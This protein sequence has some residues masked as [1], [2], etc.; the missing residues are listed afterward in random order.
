MAELILSGWNLNQG[1]IAINNWYSGGSSVLSSTTNNTLLNTNSTT[2]VAPGVTWGIGFGKGLNLISGA[3]ATGLNGSGNSLS[4]NFSLIVNGRANTVSNIYSSIINGTYD[5]WS[6]TSMATP[7]VTGAAVLLAS[8]EPNLS[9]VDMKKRIISTSRPISGLRGK[10]LGGLID[11]YS[12]IT[13]T[14][15]PPDPND[16]ANWKTMNVSVSSAHPYKDNSKE[17][18]EVKVPGAK[19]ISLYFT[20][21]DTERD[22][23]KVE[24]YNSSGV[25][26]GE[27]SG[28]NDDS[29][30]PIVDGELVKIVFTSDD[31]VNRYG[32]DISKAAWK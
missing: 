10:S 32:F 14:Q 6:G 5:S 7:H 11:A 9:G 31:S 2:M 12:M 28:K 27:M 20:K 15:A 13:N 25:K 18:F 8:H 21:F 16:P 24:L 3:Y 26:V 1:R 29:Y 23:D 19:Q 17:T 30:S 22:Y 4:N